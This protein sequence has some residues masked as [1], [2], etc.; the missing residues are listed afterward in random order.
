MCCVFCLLAPP[1]TCPRSTLDLALPRSITQE[2]EHYSL[3]HLGSLAPDFQLDLAHGRHLQEIR[4][5]G[6]GGQVG[7][8]GLVFS[9][10]DPL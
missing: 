3:H 6:G 2:T 7:I 1:H 8:F 9:L 4:R 5:V 10:L